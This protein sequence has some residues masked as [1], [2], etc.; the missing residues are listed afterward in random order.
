MN[1]AEGT[2][3]Y[4]DAEHI[5]LDEALKSIAQG[6]LTNSKRLGSFIAGVFPSHFVRGAQEYLYDFE[7]K[8]YVDYLCNLGTNLFGYTNPDISLAIQRA[9]PQG[10]GFSLGSPSEVQFARMFKMKFPFV[11]KIKI[12]KSGSEGC[13]AA[14]RIARE[15]TQRENVM[16]DGYHGW[17]D[18]Y[19]SMTPPANGV[20]RIKYPID[21]LELGTID[22]TIA[23]VIVEPVITDWSDDRR[24]YLSRLREQCTKVG[25]LLIFDETITA[26]RFP[27]Y[28]VAGYWGIEPDL[29][30]CGKALANGMP[31]SVVGGKT[32]VMDGDYFVS[33]T[34]ACERL[35]LEAA[36]ACLQLIGGQYNPDHLWERGTQFIESMN[37]VLNPLITVKGYP[38]RGTFEGNN[39]AR[40]LF[41]QEMCKLG[42]FFHPS[43]WF[44]N[45]H[46]H[47]H[48]DDVV[49]CAANVMVRIRN[50]SVKLEGSL[51]QSP[52]KKQGH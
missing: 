21:Q 50:G 8:Q 42:F 13:S 17:H 27:N 32:A 30:V 41:I 38:S 44:Y 22:E 5:C 47:N 45:I 43:T 35:T 39:M 18:E 26:Y 40:G 51:F 24:V 23:A 6:A 12:L 37:E 29:I 4:F 46:L 7:G 3:K 36:I 9:I 28:S 49:D 19:V 14:K 48:L 25:A 33:A 31:I 20:P 1:T 52:F 2:A 11:D 10:V 15:Y 34:Y 16:S